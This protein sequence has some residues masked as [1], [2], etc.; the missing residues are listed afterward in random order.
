MRA[1]HTSNFGV[2]RYLKYAVNSHK[3]GVT[4]GEKIDACPPSTASN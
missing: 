4:F 1:G 3:L 2:R